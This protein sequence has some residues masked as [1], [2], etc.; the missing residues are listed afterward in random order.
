MHSLHCL[1]L[2]VVRHGQSG[3]MLSDNAN[4][5]R[6][7]AATLKLAEEFLAPHRTDWQSTKNSHRGKEACTNEYKEA[8]TKHRH[9]A[10]RKAVGSRLL[11][12]IDF[13]TLTVEVEALV[14]QWPPTFVAFDSL[15]VIRAVDSLQLEAHVHL[16]S[17]EKLADIV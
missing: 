8:C 1:R 14:N 12:Y 6:L 10:T 17:G 5:F 13:R 7:T 16:D 9:G 3:F 15:E 11:N 4:N 2:L